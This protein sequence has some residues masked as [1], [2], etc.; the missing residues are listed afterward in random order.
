MYT[1][2]LSGNE[3]LKVGLWPEACTYLDKLVP[4]GGDNHGVLGVR[5]EANAR[6]PVGVALIGDGV[7][8]VTEGVPELDGS[9]TGTG[10]NLAVVGRE[11]DG[12]NVAVV[13]NESAGGGTGSELPETESLVPRGGEGIG[14]IGGDD[15]EHVSTPR[16]LVIVGRPTSQDVHIHSR[17]RCGSDRGGFAWGSRIGSRRG[18]GSR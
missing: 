18:S 12:E 10:N 14:T 16:T 8:A 15:L 17:R 4:A 1:R 3:E 13:A 5:A 7:L 11:R 9:V 2:S 6:D